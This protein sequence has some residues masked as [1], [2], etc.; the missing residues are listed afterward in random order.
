MYG[1]AG[2]AMNNDSWAPMN[3]DSPI[4]LMFVFLPC[5]NCWG[6]E[7]FP[8]ADFKF[9]IH[10]NDINLILLS[11]TDFDFITLHKFSFNS[12][13]SNLVFNILITQM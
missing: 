2:A 4:I 11:V 12:S 9:C 3:N 1:D 13:T 8:L 5:G 10:S 7:V 6:T